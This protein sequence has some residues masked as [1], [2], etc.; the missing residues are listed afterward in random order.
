MKHVLRRSTSALALGVAFAAAGCGGGSNGET[1]S[2]GVKTETA[3]QAVLTYF[4]QPKPQIQESAGA[5]S[6][7]GQ[8]GAT[9]TNITLNP[10]QTLNNTYIAFSRELNDDSLQSQIYTVPYGGD[11]ATL[12]THIPGGPM[13]PSVSRNGRIAFAAYDWDQIGSIRPDGS[14]ENTVYFNNSYNQHNPTYSPDGTKIAFSGSND[15]LY[16]IPSGGGTSKAVQTN[17]LGLGIAWDPTSS[18]L[19]YEAIS[20]SYQVIYTTPDGGGTATEIS[21]TAFLGPGNYSNPTWSQNG[22]L[23]LSSFVP[24]GDS[25]SEIVEMS[26]HDNVGTV[27]SP[28]GVNDNYP[29]FSPDGT[30]VAFYRDSTGGATPGVYVMDSAGTNPEL[31]IPD[32]SG[33]YTI[34]GPVT[35]VAWSPFLI[36]E[37]F[38]GSGANFYSANVSG[39]LMGQNGSQ[40]GSIVGF[41]ASTP[42]TATITTPT[43]TT[44]TAPLVFTLGANSIT[45]LVYLNSYFGSGVVVN[46]S[47]TTPTVFVTIDAQTGQVDLVAP[48]ATSAVTPSATQSTSGIVTYTGKFKALYDGTGKNLAPSG[49]AQL[50]V[51]TKTGKLV[52][53]K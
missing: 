33:S 40:F 34:T 51:N 23:V 1:S 31:V 47:G 17:D 9:Y 26:P 39:F 22:N 35:G 30:K 2:S 24:N 38:F 41:I 14:L 29:A 18:L 43:T 44:G 37:Q 52:S 21:P 53:F 32:P 3:G 19:A 45:T 15:T 48:A 12:L 42:S 4:G 13:Q 16:Y 20:G 28:S 7:F 25:D 36:A 46:F 11:T 5:V 50:V 27:L 6:V 8:A 49:A 10:I